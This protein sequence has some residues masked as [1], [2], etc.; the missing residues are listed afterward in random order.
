VILFE[1]PTVYFA[2]S[3]VEVAD[4]F[5]Q[6]FIKAPFKH[7][8]L[9]INFESTFSLSHKLFLGSKVYIT[10]LV[11]YSSDAYRIVVF[12]VAVELLLFL[13]VCENSETMS[14]EL[15]YFSDVGLVAA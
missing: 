8:V 11:D 5:F 9:R 14:F 7:F 15:S 2:I 12:K 10:V 4:A 13:I 1:L 6:V 3:V